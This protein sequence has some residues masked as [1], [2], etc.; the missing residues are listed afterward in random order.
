M[1]VKQPRNGWLGLD[2]GPKSIEPGRG[3]GDDCSDKRQSKPVAHEE[4][5][6]SGC[7]R[8]EIDNQQTRP[9]SLEPSDDKGDGSERSESDKNRGAEEPG[10]V[11]AGKFLVRDVGELATVPE[12]RDLLRVQGRGSGGVLHPEIKPLSVPIC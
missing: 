8:R 1:F 9:T 6:V 2:R 12:E 4:R 11:G 10:V 7:E 3:K 5:C